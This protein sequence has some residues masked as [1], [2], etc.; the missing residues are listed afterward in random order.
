MKIPKANSSNAWTEFITKTRVI[1]LEKKNY[2][3]I[4]FEQIIARWVNAFM[5]GHIFFLVVIM[6]TEF[7]S[8]NIIYYFF[9]LDLKEINSFMLLN[10]HTFFFFFK[11][12]F[13]ASQNF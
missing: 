4:S 12:T 11:A 1:T 6:K 8:I 7:V 10:C 9:L 2:F 5:A 3:W 13:A